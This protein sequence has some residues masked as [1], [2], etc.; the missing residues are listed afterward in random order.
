MKARRISR[1]VFLFAA[2]SFCGAFP[3]HS[4]KIRIALEGMDCGRAKVFRRG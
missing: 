3:L 2:R 4:L 1:R